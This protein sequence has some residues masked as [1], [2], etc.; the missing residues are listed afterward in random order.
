MEELFLSV[1]WEAAEPDGSP[2]PR[3]CLRIGTDSLL[4]HLPPAPVVPALLQICRALL[5]L[6][7]GARD[8]VTIALPGESALELAIEGPHLAAQVTLG[9]GLTLLHRTAVPA[10]P[11]I[12]SVAAA[13]QDAL[14]AA[15]GDDPLTRSLALAAAAL[16][17][18][19]AELPDA[20]SRTA[21]PRELPRPDRPVRLEMTD[22]SRLVV[23]LGQ[24]QVE[25]DD[26]DTQTVGHA[27][28]EA[29]DGLLQTREWPPGVQAVGLDPRGA[30]RLVL[31]RTS[32]G[33]LACVVDA[34]Q[35]DLCPPWPI[36][37]GEL[38]RAALRC[39]QGLPAEADT[40]RRALLR[41][42]R[43]EQALRRP[44]TLGGRPPRGYRPPGPPAPEAD[45]EP[46]PVRR[47]RHLAW[48]RIWRHEAPGLIR[49][50]ATPRALLVHGDAGVQAL[51]PE[52]GQG[53]W[54]RADLRPL[55]A[56]SPGLM[57]DADGGLVAL[58][59]ATGRLRWRSR[60]GDDGH[61]RSAWRAAGG[62]VALS[63]STV[64]GLDRRG[65]IRW[66]YDTWFGH[67]IH[68][69][70]HGPLAWMIA[71][72]GMLH[73]IRLADGS[74]QFVVPLRGEP[75]QG[76][77]L[78]PAG[79]LV[80]SVREPEAH[81]LVA[82]LDPVRGALSWRVELDAAPVGAPVVVGDVVI[83]ATGSAERVGLEALGLADGATRWRHQRLP[84]GGLPQLSALDDLVLC[85]ARD[86][87]V[88]AIDARSGRVVWGLGG[89]DAD[90]L[91]LHAPP[92]VRRR[93]VL[94]VPGA[95]IRA[96]DPGTGRVIQTLDCGELVPAWL[97]AWPDG[98][99]IIA[100]DDA[101]A[102]YV[103][104]GHLSLVQ[105]SSV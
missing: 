67:V 74:R 38:A 53:R 45:G 88:V 29:V 84:L 95:T 14:A 75:E 50:Q 33:V 61:F 90:G 31:R 81:A 49:V 24:C 82:L 77:L 28:V 40:W 78:C 68:V 86:A 64:F 41:L 1:I 54:S 100:E 17:D 47:L 23:G 59:P 4:A 56:G 13:T 27:L 89:D 97:H 105:G 52:S 93:G 30:R 3:L 25:V 10:R 32:E 39:L 5:A 35:H 99:L 34:A 96:V 19:P 26:T 66:R 79:V 16:A 37:V 8:R 101:V 43:W 46:L 70:L 18:L 55:D 76:P 71:E 6:A 103:L 87:S 80:T 20:P 48:R 9:Q 62:L 22:P 2:A 51:D 94:L 98:D 102:R 91:L 42:I 73:A 63:D 60:T 104:G 58:E 57:R 21:P 11:L 15:P 44:T 65:G 72:D 69:A 36:E 7:S 85:R 12:A 92:P 83:Q